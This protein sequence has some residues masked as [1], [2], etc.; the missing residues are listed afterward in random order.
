[1]IQNYDVRRHYW[2]E[3]KEWLVERPFRE[4]EKELN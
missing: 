3:G 2:K 1:M 4:L